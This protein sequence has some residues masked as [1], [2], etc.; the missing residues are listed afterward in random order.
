[1]ADRRGIAVAR[2]A[3]IDQVAVGERGAR[4]HRGHP[5]VDAVEAVRLPEEIRRRLRRA[6]D[7]RKLRHLVRRDRQLEERLDDRR[8]DRI[9]AAAGAERRDGPLVVAAR[10]AELVL[11]QVRVMELRFGEVGHGATLRSGLTLKSVA[12]SAIS[13]VMKRAVSGLPS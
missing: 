5:A 7:A 13:R 3:E 4:K 8:R 12:F 6:A 10:E 9:M 11:R 1:E 2:D